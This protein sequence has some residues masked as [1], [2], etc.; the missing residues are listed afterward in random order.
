M[1][2]VSDQLA[3]GFEFYLNQFESIFSRIGD[4]QSAIL[5]PAIFLALL[6]LGSLVHRITRPWDSKLFA[7]ITHVPNLTNNATRG[8][9]KPP[10]FLFTHIYSC[11]ILI[12]ASLE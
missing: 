3:G 11:L 4:Q 10:K 12:V 7:K 1:T 6:F 8:L 2:K 9:A 5:D